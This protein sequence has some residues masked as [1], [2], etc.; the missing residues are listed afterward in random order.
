MTIKVNDTPSFNISLNLSVDCEAEAI[1]FTVT[2]WNKKN[3][4]V[5]RKKFSAHD[6]PASLAYFREKEA[7]LSE[8]KKREIKMF[9]E[10]DVYSHLCNYEEAKVVGVIAQSDEAAEL[11]Y[12]DIILIAEAIYR[13]WLNTESSSYIN[14]L[15]TYSWLRPVSETERGYIQ[16]YAERTLPYFL[17]I[18]FEGSVQERVTESFDNELDI[19]VLNPC[20]FCKTLQMCKENEA[21]YKE[22]SPRHKDTWTEYKASL[23]T[24][25]YSKDYGCSSTVSYQQE[26][27]NF[28]PTCGKRIEK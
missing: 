27:L 19:S 15:K 20:P 17:E 5:E 23:V 21:W 25:G 18:Y 12:E 26:E 7:E 14:F 16:E 24:E 1:E 2:S 22:N 4:A 28:C 11:D 8:G 3:D 10:F 9:N 6:F 13:H